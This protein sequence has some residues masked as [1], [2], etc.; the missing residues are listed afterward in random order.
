MEGW[1]ECV[2]PQKTLGASGVNRVASEFNTIEVTGDSFFSRNKKTAR[3][4]GREV[5]VGADT[6]MKPREHV[7][8]VF[9]YFYYV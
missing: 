7:V 2:G 6:W 1:V 8:F 9:C 3:A 5:D 4:L